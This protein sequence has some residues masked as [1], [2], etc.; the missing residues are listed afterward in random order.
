M[1][2][3]CH[4]APLTLLVFTSLVFFS[5]N[6]A[7][8]AV[9]PHK[10]LI[11]DDG[12]VVN[13]TQASPFLGSGSTI[14]L[15]EKGIVKIAYNHA[16]ARLN[17]SASQ[18][19]SDLQRAFVMLEGIA[20]LDF[21]F[22]G[23][24]SA[25]PLD[26]NDNVVVVGWEQIGGNSIARAGPASAGFFSTVQR[27]GYLPAIDGSFTFNSLHQSDYELSTMI[28]ELMHLLGVGH[29]DTPVSIM[30]PAVS[31]YGLPQADDIAVLQAMYGPPDEFKLEQP[32]IALAGAPSSGI[33][34]DPADSGLRVRPANA[35]D[36]NALNT[37]LRVNSTFNDEDEIFYRLSY[38]GADVGETV[39]IFVTDPNG[40]TSLSTASTLQFSDR[41]S[42]FFVG[43]AK[44]MTAIAGD[45]TIDIGVSGGLVQRLIIPVDGGLDLSNRNPIAG[46]VATPLNGG[47]FSLTANAQD[48]EGDALNFAWHIPGE[49][50]FTNSN[51][52]ITTSKPIS[53]PV[54][55]L[56]AIRDD[57]SKRDG[58]SSGDG[59][60]AL[61]SQYLAT[62]AETNIP[63]YFGEEEILHIPSI[64]IG[65]VSFSVN[66]KLTKLTG[67]QFKFIELFPG[68]TQTPSS[69]IDL[70]AGVLTI[71]RLIVR[72]GGVDSVFENLSFDLV[73]SANP[74][75]FA[76]R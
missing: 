2:R 31:R 12:M 18:I 48:P 47:H 60:G 8:L 23:E 67:I 29:S 42:F 21:Q 61:L 22:L 37:V 34:V 57:G 28:H 71:P 70:I 62:P 33:N 24:S 45:W 69:S 14:T 66:F 59:F 49:G 11:Y 73:N 52:T 74:I 27:L 9:E 65:G 75:R 58:S 32:L 68:Q 44:E 4:S 51:S 39:E 40:F 15:W 63:T 46:L 25:N 19:M 10:L 36:Q 30:T 6:Q 64:L 55:V 35:S 16:G 7:L 38:R 3:H 53:S 50:E 54:R 72:A 56:A 13:T 41:I 5:V 76:L 26:F 43:L 20:E 1:F 17:V